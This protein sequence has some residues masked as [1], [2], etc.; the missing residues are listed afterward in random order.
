MAIPPSTTLP[1]AWSA[2]ASRQNHYADVT[3][4]KCREWKRGSG[5]SLPAEEG[6]EVHARMVVGFRLLSFSKGIEPM[7]VHYICAHN[8]QP[9]LDNDPKKRDGNTPFHHTARSLVRKG[10]P[11]EPGRRCDSTREAINA[12]D[13]RG[14]QA[15]VYRGGQGGTRKGLRAGAGA[16]HLCALWQSHS[17][18]PALDW[19]L[20]HG[21]RSPLLF[22]QYI[23]IAACC[24]VHARDVQ[25][26]A[27]RI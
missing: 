13:E 10:V 18:K 7:P 8:L 12:V 24:H 6:K 15:A 27:E 19:L 16:P 14:D 26:V 2:K 23:A 21:A 25:A 1:P 3:P 20:A 9:L 17:L 5:R 22:D 4:Q 11:P